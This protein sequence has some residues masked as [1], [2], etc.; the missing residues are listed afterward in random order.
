M[1]F[2]GR[3]LVVCAF[4]G[5]LDCGADADDKTRI[6]SLYSVEINTSG[7]DCGVV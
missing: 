2:M 1:F 3:C 5:G 4:I 6:T 7:C